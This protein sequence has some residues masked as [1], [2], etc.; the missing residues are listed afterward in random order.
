MGKNPHQTKSRSPQTANLSRKVQK[1]PHQ[2]AFRPPQPANP[3]L[4]HVDSRRLTGF[5]FLFATRPK[6]QLRLK[7]CA[8]THTLR[9]EN[10][11]AVRCGAI[12]QQRLETVAKTHTKPSPTRP[13]LQTCLEKCRKSQ[14][15]RHSARPKMQSRLS[16]PFIHGHSV[17][18]RS[19]CSSFVPFVH[20]LNSCP[21]I[22][23]QTANPSLIH[24]DSRDLRD[25]RSSL[26]PAPKCKFVSETGA[27]TDENKKSEQFSDDDFFDNTYFGGR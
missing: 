3:F 12:L 17:H 21:G 20:S 11:E 8:K 26:P 15:N 4:I 1:K 25:S 7:T 27:A 6:V 23:T 2:Q 13:K 19:S 10:S 14:T 16:F 24:A 18:S 5:T 9:N 22:Q